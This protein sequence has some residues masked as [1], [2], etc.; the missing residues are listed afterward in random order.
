MTKKNGH[1]PASVR[2][3]NRKNILDII[4]NSGEITVSRIA[5]EIQLSKTTLWKVIDYFQE[6]NLVINSG[7]DTNSDELGKK[8][9]L[10]RFN[11]S[12]AYV[13][14][15]AIYEK[16][17]LLALTDARA[18]IF[19]KETVY[20]NENENLYRIISIIAS[21]IEKWQNQRN[22]PEDRKKSNLI[23]I[24]IASSGV[25]DSEQGFCFTASRFHSW[26]LKA[27]IKKLIEEKVRITAPIYIDNYNRFFV[28]AEKELGGYKNN[29]NIIS[30]VSTN[31]GLGAGIIADNKIKR[32]P[33][34][35]TGEIGHMRLDPNYDEP[36][37]CGGSGCFEQLVSS[38]VLYRRSR[39]E[40]CEHKDSVIYKNESMD[41]RLD[42]I[43]SAA[44]NGDLWAKELLDP[45]I[46][47]FAIGIQNI[48][49]VF[50]PEVIIM[51]G[52]YR[53][54]GEYF[55]NKLTEIIDGISLTRMKKNIQIEYSKFDEEGTILGAASYIIHDYF[56]NV[57]KY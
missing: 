22:L 41:L 45:I 46:Q 36:C 52:E 30:I 10:Y 23:G 20:L 21:F 16:T 5:K 1:N 56:S 42:D 27:E 48:V 9:D 51:G 18:R 37:H 11:A 47:W 12:Y 35:L 55:Q 49:L 31:G 6:K 15:F 8:P 38:D 50:N 2:I 4:R 19:Y 32:G 17:I 3:N 25:I 14:T 24:A 13:I 40:R 33:E 57:F 44:D 39:E 28:F 43:F 29:K 53:N 7:K 26:P 54:P 34:F